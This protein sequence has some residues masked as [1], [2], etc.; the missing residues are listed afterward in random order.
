MAPELDVQGKRGRYTIVDG[1]FAFGRSS[2]LSEAR[3]E[4]G[5]V[6]CLKVFRASPKGPAGESLL[7]EFLRELTAQSKLGHPNILPILD[8]SEDLSDGG[9]PFLVLPLCRGGN[10]REFMG[11]KQFVPLSEAIPILQQIAS[12]VDFAHDSGFIHGDI[13]PENILLSEDHTRAFLCDFSM[14]KY[15]AV[16]EQ[17]TPATVAMTGGST[18]Y[19]SPEQISEG[20]QSPRSDIYSLATVAYEMLTG[21]LPFD[22]QVPPYRQ[23]EAKIHGRLKDPGE[24]NSTLSAAIQAALL[25][26]LSADSKDRPER[27]AEFCRLLLGGNAY[28]N[29]REPA[30]PNKLAGFW[31]SLENSHKVAIITAIIAATAAVVGAIIA[32]IFKG[33]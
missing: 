18:A 13:K 2:V 17:I 21:S 28:R 14:A 12:A 25:R 4:R 9:A 11:R 29:D 3:D 32:A 26:G 1:P 8:F 16:E 23:M 10:L 20:R 24:A 22:V 31:R 33:K 5:Q 30:S 6:V 7:A 27:A 15:F 19:L